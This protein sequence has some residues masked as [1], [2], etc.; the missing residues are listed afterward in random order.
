MRPG[1]GLEHTPDMG[2]RKL[3]V[4]GNCVLSG[5]A[6]SKASSRKHASR[7]GEQGSLRD[8]SRDK[9]SLHRMQADEKDLNEVRQQFQVAMKFKG[10]GETFYKHV[11]GSCRIP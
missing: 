3:V 4:T 9:D 11:S 8:G 5:V 2:E 6:E 7:I 10:G 1:A